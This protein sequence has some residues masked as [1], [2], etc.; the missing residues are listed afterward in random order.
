MWCPFKPQGIKRSKDQIKSFENMCMSNLVGWC[1][2][3]QHYFQ[4]ATTQKFI[5]DW[6]VFQFVF[7][8][9]KL[10]SFLS[11]H[12]TLDA[13]TDIIQYQPGITT[14]FR[15]THPGMHHFVFWVSKQCP[16]K[17]QKTRTQK[18]SSTDNQI[19]LQCSQCKHAV[20]LQLDTTWTQSD[21]KGN[22]GAWLVLTEMDK[23]SDANKMML[24]WLSFVYF[25]ENCLCILKK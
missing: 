23:K 18:Q 1:C 11:D 3:S 14:Y 9:I 25:S 12:Q 13:Q 16:C 8:H 17:R 21:E 5:M 2:F 4:P 7:E 15:W 20:C 6:A 24:T 19:L 10:T 22:E